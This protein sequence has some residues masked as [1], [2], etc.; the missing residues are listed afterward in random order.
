MCF[1][2]EIKKNTGFHAVCYI[3]TM[4]RLVQIETWFFGIIHCITHVDFVW[5]HLLIAGDAYISKYFE[6]RELVVV[7]VYTTVFS[8]N[9][10]TISYFARGKSE[11]FRGFLKVLKLDPQ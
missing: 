1:S 4:P 8:K 10:V 9:F 2:K 6:R 7:G 5:R 3:G 11:G